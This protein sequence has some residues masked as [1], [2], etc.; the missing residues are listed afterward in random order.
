MSI[1]AGLIG[2]G[3][4]A[5]VASGCSDTPVPAPV[6]PPKVVSDPTKPGSKKTRLPPKTGSP[7]GPSGIAP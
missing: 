4:S 1:R 6:E 5:F 7:T 3:L 2:L